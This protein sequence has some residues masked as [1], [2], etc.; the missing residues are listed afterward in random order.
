MNKQYYS[1]ISFE[2]IKKDTI[3]SHIKQFDSLEEAFE[4][5]DSSFF[6]IKERLN[7]ENIPGSN[8]F[9][10]NIFKYKIINKNQQPFFIEFG[11]AK[12]FDNSIKT[13][14]LGYYYSDGSAEVS[15]LDRDNQVNKINVST[16]FDSE[17]DTIVNLIEFLIDFENSYN[18][19]WKNYNIS[20]EKNI[21][22]KELEDEIKIANNKV[23]ELLNQNRI[24]KKERTIL[25]K[26]NKNE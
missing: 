17:A 8:L 18:A 12:L 3:S 25:R 20:I 19:D 22:I 23:S 4:Y 15:I 24:L 11:R 10:P 6:I 7:A 14:R 13:Y 16:N 5:K 1:V 2:R 9:Y 26:L 21:K